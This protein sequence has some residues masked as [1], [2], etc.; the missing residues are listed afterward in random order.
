MAG[1]P[2]YKKTKAKAVTATT[3]NLKL[4]KNWIKLSKEG[5][6]LA[7]DV[8]S[9]LLL[10][11]TGVETYVSKID[12]VEKDWLPA[13]ESLV[14]LQ[15]ELKVA[16]K[17]KKTAEIE[18]LKMKIQIAEKTYNKYAKHLNHLFGRMVDRHHESKDLA[19]AVLKI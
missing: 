1:I 17:K 18:E 7:D 8:H 9:S 12:E 2:D 16:R 14:D 19:E 6:G 10:K 11:E 5:A 4:Y 3:H 13:V 15:K